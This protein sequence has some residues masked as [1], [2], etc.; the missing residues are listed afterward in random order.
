MDTE[1][2]EPRT[3]S[4]NGT[5][6]RGRAVVMELEHS[7]AGQ[8]EE[9]RGGGGHVETEQASWLL[10]VA[11]EIVVEET[12]PLRHTRARNSQCPPELERSE[13]E[14]GTQL[15]ILSCWSKPRG[16]LRASLSLRNLHCLSRSEIKFSS[17]K[18]ALLADGA[19]MVQV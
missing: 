14:H 10:Y 13:C 2:F 7:G 5:V 12:S 18:V 8:G 9:G 15:L 1:A 17:G 11:G 6:V 3:A 4:G 19:A 16:S